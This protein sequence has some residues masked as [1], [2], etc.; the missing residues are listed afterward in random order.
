MMTG[1]EFPAICLGF[2]LGFT[3]GIWSGFKLWR[4]TYVRIEKAG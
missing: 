3:A 4:Q 2:C 1:F